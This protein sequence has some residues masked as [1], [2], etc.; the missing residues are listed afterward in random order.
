MT[1]VGTENKTVA[2][3]Q[4]ENDSELSSKLRKETGVGDLSEV[5]VKSIARTYCVF[6]L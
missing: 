3:T 5:R 6:H 1:P 4:A 2:K